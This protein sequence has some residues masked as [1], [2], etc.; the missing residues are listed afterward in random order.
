MLL[1]HDL[2]LDTR[3]MMTKVQGVLR[4]VEEVKGRRRGEVKLRRQ[5]VVRSKNPLCHNTA[6]N[7][8]VNTLAPY[9]TSFVIGS[10]GTLGSYYLEVP[11][12]TWTAPW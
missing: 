12:T 2:D 3:W 5:W 9:F 11:Q 7:S 6:L 10:C 4:V 8:K 1:K